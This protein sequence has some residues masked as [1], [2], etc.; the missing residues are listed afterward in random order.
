MY[1]VAL[2]LVPCEQFQFQMAFITNKLMIAL[3]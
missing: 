1:E 3:R 2:C